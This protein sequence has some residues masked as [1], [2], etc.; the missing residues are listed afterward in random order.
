MEYTCVAKL[1]A[2]KFTHDACPSESEA[3]CCCRL[4]VRGRLCRWMLQPVY[5][6]AV[7]FKHVL[8]ALLHAT[9][10]LR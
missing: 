8:E 9:G 6:W 7:L 1:E 2:E 3:G 10:V 5:C 4:G